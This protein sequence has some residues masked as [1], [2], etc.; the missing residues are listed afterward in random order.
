MTLTWWQAII[1]NYKTCNLYTSYWCSLISVWS[2]L[3]VWRLG[4][5]RFN[6]SRSNSQPC[7]ILPKHLWDR[8]FWG[9]HDIQFHMEFYGLCDN[10]LWCTSDWVDNNY[11]G[12]KT[13]LFTRTFNSDICVAWIKLTTRH[14]VLHSYHKLCTRKI[15]K[16]TASNCRF[17]TH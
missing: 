10:F 3:L 1:L 2:M 14:I 15:W 11:R 9:Y 7:L 6:W 8:Y 13:C 5:R 12:N 17:M 16:S 4:M